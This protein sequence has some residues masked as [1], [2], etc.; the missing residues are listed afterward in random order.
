[1]TKRPYDISWN[2]R[3]RKPLNCVLGRFSSCQTCVDERLGCNI[4]LILSIKS[5]Y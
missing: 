3:K 1:M 5:D 4:W 2:N